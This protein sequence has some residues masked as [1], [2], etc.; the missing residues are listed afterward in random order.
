MQLNPVLQNPVLQNL[1]LFYSL[2]EFQLSRQLFS[3]QREYHNDQKEG[4]YCIDH[5]LVSEVLHLC[6]IY[7]VTSQERICTFLHILHR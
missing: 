3:K 6:D 2:I 4:W 1:L 7:L 5:S